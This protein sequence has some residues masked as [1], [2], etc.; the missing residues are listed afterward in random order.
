MT[1]EKKQ[2][3]ITTFGGDIY[4][5]RDKNP[6]QVQDLIDS[7]GD[8]VRMPNGARINKKGIASIQDYEDYN[9]QADQ[10]VRHKKG[11]YLKRGGWHDIQGSL[12]IDSHLERITGEMLKIAKPKTFDRL[13]PGFNPDGSLAEMSLMKKG[14]E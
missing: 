2:S 13:E 12:G 14:D 10:K 3:I 1:L 11:Q 8:M 6:D 7:G 4:I 5:I 9:F